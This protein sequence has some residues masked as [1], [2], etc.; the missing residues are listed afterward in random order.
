MKIDYNLTT[1]PDQEC[2]VTCDACKKQISVKDGFVF[3]N[4]KFVCKNRYCLNAMYSEIQQS[5]NIRAILAR[6]IR[7]IFL[8]FGLNE[9]KFT[10]IH[11]HLITSIVDSIISTIESTNYHN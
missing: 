9:C 1:L 10:E 7:D 8:E 6:H 2:L 5:S 11:H 4:G 3:E